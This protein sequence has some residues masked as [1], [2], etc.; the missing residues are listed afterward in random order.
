MNNI[1]VS[2]DRDLSPAEARAILGGFNP[3]HSYD[4]LPK[5]QKGLMFDEALKRSFASNERG[6]L[7]R[8]FFN[9]VR[10]LAKQR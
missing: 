8:Q 6:S 5:V 3:M 10:D 1:S 9:F 2:L 4:D 7:G